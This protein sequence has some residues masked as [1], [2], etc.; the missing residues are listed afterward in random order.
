MTSPMTMNRVIHGA[1]RRDLTRFTAALDSFRD[2]DTAR[3][4]HLARAFANLRHE[5]TNH[6]ESEDAHAWPAL[7]KLG[8]DQE[9]LAAMVSEHADMAAALAESDTA[10]ATL[11]RTGTASDAAA[12]RASLERTQ[13]VVD[14]HLDHE[15]ADLEPIIAKYGETPEWK[16]VEKQFRRHPPTV[17]GPFFAWVTDGMEDEERAYFRKSLPPPVVSV[18]AKVFGRRYTRQI[19]PTWRTPAA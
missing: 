10:L 3:A 14:R 7:R 1:V 5:L 4:G 18:F 12:A 11:A 15:E 16:A 6:H 9:L 19:A 2:G 8:V 17:I 13:Q